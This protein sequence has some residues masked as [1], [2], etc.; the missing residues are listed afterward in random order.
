MPKPRPSSTPFLLVRFL[1]PHIPN[2]PQE[3]PPVQTWASLVQSSFKSMLWQAPRNL[4]R[5]ELPPLSFCPFFL[6]D[7]FSPHGSRCNELKERTS[8]RGGARPS[9]SA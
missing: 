2:R 5:D 7:C 3:S 8:E 4:A 6:S 1:P 9:T